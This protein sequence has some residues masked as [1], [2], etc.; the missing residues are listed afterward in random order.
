MKKNMIHHR[1]RKLAATGVLAAALCSVAYSADAPPESPPSVLQAIEKALADGNSS[2]KT[3]VSAFFE[4]QNSA[5]NKG[6]VFGFIQGDY[7]T[8]NYDGLSAGAGF[9]FA[10][11]IW[12]DKSGDYD[13]KFSAPA[14][15]R[16]LYLRYD[17][18][19]WDNTYLA[20]GRVGLADSPIT[21]GDAGDGL[22]GSVGGPLPFTFTGTAITRWVHHAKASWDGH[23]SGTEQVKNFYPDAGDV[24]LNANVEIPVR[25]GFTVTPSVAY[26]QHVLAVYAAT[27]EL[28]VP[29]ETFGEGVRWRTEVIGAFHENEATSSVT[30]A[31]DFDSHASS[32][33]IFTGLES[34][35]GSIG[36]GAYAL[37]DDKL[38]LDPG[39]FSHFD[40][41]NDDDLFPFNDENDA[42][43][44]YTKGTYSLGSLD[45]E[46]HFGAGRNS[47]RDVSSDSYEVDLTAVYHFSK[48]LSLK[49]EYSTVQFENQDVR[50]GGDY[51][52]G[53]GMLRY[54]F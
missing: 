50:D 53:G 21:H 38:N 34:N 54:T 44:F 51:Q 32:G 19:D 9:V 40:P 52:K 16:R 13:S 14:K 35:Q 15:V 20:G 17:F 5:A 4:D 8:K 42:Q 6:F 3:G 45:L 48:K 25:S 43:L 22:T 2:V 11:E 1:P 29:V 39:A 23:I 24:F 12:E 26:Q 37:S 49:I 10:P 31:N 46:A 36:V 28:V 30:E 27:A 47:S 33:R 7:Q 18:T 41:L